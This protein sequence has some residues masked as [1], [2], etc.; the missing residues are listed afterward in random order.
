MVYKVSH[1]H[2][3]NILEKDND[4]QEEVYQEDDSAD[5]RFICEQP[6]MD[7]LTFWHTNADAEVVT[8]QENIGGQSDVGQDEFICEDVEEDDT[9]VD[10]DSEGSIHSSYMEDD[11]QNEHISHDNDNSD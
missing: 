11:E 3:W 9:L 6:D 4:V 2:L 7:L 8:I 1:R 5:L 10:Y